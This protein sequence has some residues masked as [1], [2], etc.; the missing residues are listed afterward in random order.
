M[1]NKEERKL[2]KELLLMTR[3]SQNVKT[4]IAKKLGKQYLQIGEALLKS[5]GGP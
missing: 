4:Y 5:M 3:N 1:L 2:L